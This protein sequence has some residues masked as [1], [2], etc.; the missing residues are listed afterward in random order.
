M[1]PE[2]RKER[3]NRFCSQTDRHSKTIRCQ[4]SLG[5]LEDCEIIGLVS[6]N[7]GTCFGGGEGRNLGVPAEGRD[8]L[9]VLILG[10]P[11]QQPPV[12]SPGQNDLRGGVKGRI[13]SNEREC[14]G[15]RCQR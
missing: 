4:K 5:D 6:D 11:Q 9:S 1:D 2:K 10:I 12:K 3:E 13:V 8:R 14:G 7:N 15:N